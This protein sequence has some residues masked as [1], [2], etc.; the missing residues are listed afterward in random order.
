MQRAA[1][2]A[3]LRHDTSLVYTGQRLGPDLMR[4]RRQ[5]PEGVCGASRW[6]QRL[7]PGLVQDMRAI[8]LSR[9]LQQVLQSSA[10]LADA[11]VLLKVRLL[12]VSPADVQCCAVLPC[13]A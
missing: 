12:F 7:S 6:W 4:T 5:A 9:H 1:A 3:R 11:V 8:E 10:S 13:A 2:S